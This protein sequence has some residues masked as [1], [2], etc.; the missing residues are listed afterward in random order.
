MRTAIFTLDKTILTI[1][2]AEAA[3]LVPMSAGVK[4]TQLNEGTNTVAV[5]PGVFKVQSHG[6]VGVTTT[7]GAIHVMATADDKDGDW[8]DPQKSMMTSSVTTTALR[9]FFA[10]DV[11]SL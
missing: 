9:Q 5:G 2:L 7:T 4:P 8:P 6:A 3:Q 10:T 11:K 1:Q